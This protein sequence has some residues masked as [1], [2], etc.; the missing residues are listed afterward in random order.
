M[1]QLTSGFAS[2]QVLS[3]CAKHLFVAAHDGN[4]AKVR[5]MF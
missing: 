3:L 2:V 1:C 4:F 5:F